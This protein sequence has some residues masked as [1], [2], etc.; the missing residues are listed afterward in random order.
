MNLL[1]LESKPI[2]GKFPKSFY[3]NW[4]KDWEGALE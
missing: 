2:L 4:P 3:Y 1:S